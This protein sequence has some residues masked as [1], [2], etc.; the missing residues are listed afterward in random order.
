M[1]F[2]ALREGV[3][4]RPDNLPTESAPAEAWRAANA[5]CAWWSGR[6]DDDP[7]ALADALF[8]SGE[9]ARRAIALEVH[10]AAV[11][12]ALAEAPDGALAGAF[13]AG[14]ASLAHLRADPLLPDELVSDASAGAALRRAY[15]AYEAEF[16][17]ALRGWFLER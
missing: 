5:Q 7:V 13:V 4:T 14:A 1:R 16:S 6:P 3:W 9:W 15:T 11:T 8:A 17:Q 2:A 12:S 10:L